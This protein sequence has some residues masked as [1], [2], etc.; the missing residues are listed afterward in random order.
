MSTASVPPVHC[1]KMAASDMSLRQRPV[2]EFL[3]DYNSSVAH[4]CGRLRCVQRRPYG[5]H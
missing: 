1:N 5:L 4:I 3:V 2:I